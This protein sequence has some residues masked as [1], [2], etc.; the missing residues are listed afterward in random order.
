MTRTNFVYRTFR[1]Q[2]L[3]ECGMK[4]L[5]FWMFI[6]LC[7]ENPTNNKASVGV[8]RSQCYSGK[9]ELTVCFR[10]TKH[11]I[12]CFVVFHKI[13]MKNKIATEFGE[14]LALQRKKRGLLQKELSALCG[15]SINYV[16][17][18]ERGEK[19]ITLEKVFIIA[20]KLE[21]SVFDLIPDER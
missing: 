12:V 7:I 19:N 15:F 9:L 11:T 21:C 10:T 4:A 18:L 20:D 2:G 16:G 6:L 17:L 1:Q 14:K 13:K 8:V 3:D 5:S